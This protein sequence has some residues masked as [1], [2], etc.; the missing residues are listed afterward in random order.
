MDMGGPQPNR[1]GPLLMRGDARAKTVGLAY[2]YGHPTIL[3]TESAEYVHSRDFVPVGTMMA[4]VE[5]V[6]KPSGRVVIR[7]MLMLCPLV[8]D[9]R[10]EVRVEYACFVN[11]RS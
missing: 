9:I 1:R 6:G 8:V 5:V 10:A 4:D 3:G 11:L 2:I 7:H